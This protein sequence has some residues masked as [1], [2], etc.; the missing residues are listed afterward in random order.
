MLPRLSRFNILDDVFDDPFFEKKENQI[1]KT[2]V[3]EKEGNYILDIDIPGYN[4]D[5]IK[6]SLA[7]GYLTVSAATKKDVDESNKKENYIHRERFYG[8]CSR[9]Y[10]AGE[11]VT[12][13]DIKAK[14]NNG[15][16]TINFPKDKEV[17]NKT[18]KF[19][20]ISD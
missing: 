18:K 20:E 12:E 17:E 1:M 3:K 15:I 10:Y 16:L 11:N 7:D 2:D 6:I 19:I 8:K 5:D 13:E 9:T 4:K 14:F